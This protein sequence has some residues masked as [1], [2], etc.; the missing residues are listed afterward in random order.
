[1]IGLISIMNYESPLFN[2]ENS[3][4]IVNATTLSETTYIPP[5]I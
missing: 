2:C 5:V 3:R 1:M 4:E